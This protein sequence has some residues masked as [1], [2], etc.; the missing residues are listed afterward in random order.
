MKLEIIK[1][2]RPLTRLDTS[3]AS[4]FIGKECYFSDDLDS[5]DYLDKFKDKLIVDGY[6]T[7]MYKGKLLGIFSSDNAFIVDEDDIGSRFDYCIPAEW[8]KEVKESKKKYRP[9]TIDTFLKKFKL[10]DSVIIRCKGN[11]TYEELLFTGYGKDFVHLG[12]CVFGFN[13]LFKSYE[14]GIHYDEFVP[15]GIEE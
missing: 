14:F 9:Y 11:D 10:G 3:E 4:Q 5:F 7:N 12:A 15:F 8:V 13:T 1:G 2:K 6:Y